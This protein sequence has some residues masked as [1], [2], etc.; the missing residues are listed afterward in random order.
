MMPQIVSRRAYDDMLEKKNQI[1]N[2]LLNAL[3]EI[4]DSIEIIPT[5]E[6]SYEDTAL[7]NIANNAIEKAKE[8]ANVS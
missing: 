5:N 1:I 8:K 3:K 7:L 4:R 6:R 2:D